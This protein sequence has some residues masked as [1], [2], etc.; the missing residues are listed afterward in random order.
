MT[1]NLL[2]LAAGLLLLCSTAVDAQMMTE[3][4]IPIGQSPG[5]SGKSS[6]IGTIT[7]VDHDARTVTVRREEGG[8]R[9]YKVT[10]DTHIW[11]DRSDWKLTNL[12]GTYRDCVVGQRVEIMHRYGD[13]STAYWIKVEARDKR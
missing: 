4:Y 3:R 7:E 11:V 9:T 6:T 10:D 1:K 5:V 13:E 8:T 12:G 2:A